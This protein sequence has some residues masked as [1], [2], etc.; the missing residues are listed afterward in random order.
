MQLAIEENFAGEEYQ[1]VVLLYDSLKQ[2]SPLIPPAIS[3]T[4]AQAA[5]KLRDTTF[6]KP[7]FR[8]LAELNLP[9]IS[10]IALN[11]LGVQAF[12][13]K[14]FQQALVFFKEAL[15][16]NPDYTK[17]RYNYELTYKKHPPHNR[18]SAVRDQVNEE[19]LEQQ[20]KVTEQDAEKK[21]LL[22]QS[23]PPRMERERALQLLD[24]LRANELQGE[25]LR[26]MGNENKKSEKNW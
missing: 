19:Q 4:A 21:D 12:R 16:D 25:S 15:N 6:S 2:R 3:L 17:A 11:Q 8:Q 22:S 18:N 14:D 5:Q 9:H 7:L 13:D 20:A 24:A 26:R 10:T 23:V 1:K